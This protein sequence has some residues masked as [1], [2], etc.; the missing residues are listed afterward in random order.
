MIRRLSIPVAAAVALMHCI[1]AAGQ[2][3]PQPGRYA[4]NAAYQDAAKERSILFRGML[5]P[6]YK[7]KHNGTCYAESKQFQKGEILYNGRLYRD[8]DLNLDACSQMVVVRSGLITATD[9][10]YVEYALIGD[11]RFVNLQFDGSIKDAPKGYCKQIHKGPV[12][13]YALITKTIE[14]DDGYHNGEDIG[15]DDPDY[16]EYTTV[17]GRQV[18]IPGYFAY[19]V[20]YYVVKDGAARQVRNKAAILKCFDKETAKSLRRYASKSGL[21]DA[22]VKVERYADEILDYWE[23]LR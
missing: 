8:V 14:M 22:E 1:A 20:K 23:G 21:N 16:Q 18:R 2:D 19:G 10:K 11:S 3:S 13:F 15:Y 12:S 17:A 5:A 9:S 4:D 7:F 6:E